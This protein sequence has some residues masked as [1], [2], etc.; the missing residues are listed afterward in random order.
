MAQDTSLNGL[1][2]QLITQIFGRR[3]A[4]APGNSS[5]SSVEYL[6]GPRAFREQVSG[7]S[8]A[9]STITSTSVASPI[10]PFGVTVVGATAASATTAYTLANPVPGVR[11]TIFNATTGSATFLTGS[12]FICSSG[13]ITSTYASVTINGKG[14]GIELLGLTTALWGVIN[15]QGITTV[16]TNFTFV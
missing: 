8:S 14:V 15:P 6:V 16:S 7:W 5:D 10:D 4:L 3:L 13:S 2:N 12:A 1:R 9:G 11:K